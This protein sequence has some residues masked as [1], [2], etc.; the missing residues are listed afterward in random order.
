MG[1]NLERELRSR[2]SGFHPARLGKHP[3][4]SK[5]NLRSLRRGRVYSFADWPNPSIP[6][7]AA[8][9]Y[10]VWNEDLFL[11]VGMS[12]RGWSAD[13]L[14]QLKGQGGKK[15][16]LVTRLASHSSGRRSGDQFCVY[17]CDR[18]VIP[19]LSR[20]QLKDIGNARLSL[21]QMTRQYIHDKLSYRYVLTDSGLEAF[22]L[23]A[24]I[25]SGALTPHG[26]PRLN[27]GK[28]P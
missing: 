23:E 26:L 15:R 22:E 20:L 10:T 4:G 11:Y 3:S 17:V 18:L 27:P 8:G 12:G 28:G 1:G 13:Q 25:K 6:E 21:D 5:P 7:V 16:G 24:E 14:N 2:R 9:V 19:Q